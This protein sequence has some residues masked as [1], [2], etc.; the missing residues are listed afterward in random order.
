MFSSKES[1]VFSESKRRR[2]EKKMDRTEGWSKREIDISERRRKR[3]EGIGLGERIKNCSSLRTW[4]NRWSRGKKREGGIRRRFN[5]TGLGRDCAVPGVE[6]NGS[7]PLGL[8]YIPSYFLRSHRW[9]PVM[10]VE[11]SITR[12]LWLP[13]VGYIYCRSISFWPPQFPSPRITGNVRYLISVANTRLARVSASTLRILRKKGK[14][15]HLVCFLW[16]VSLQK[17]DGKTDV[18]ERTG[19]GGTRLRIIRVTDSSGINGRTDRC[20]IAVR[21]FVLQD[22]SF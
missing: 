18:T 20:F 4:K 12:D 2:K 7:R 6:G 9:R 16:L 21:R 10:D 17:E 22:R 1:F 15:K 14:K 19:G 3:G 13:T 11:N 8:R 5:R